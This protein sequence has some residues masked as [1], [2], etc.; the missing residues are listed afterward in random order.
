MMTTFSMLTSK[1]TIQHDVKQ[2]VTVQIA[3]DLF[4]DKAKKH[5]LLL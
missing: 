1:V 4:K 5:S 3:A 2:H